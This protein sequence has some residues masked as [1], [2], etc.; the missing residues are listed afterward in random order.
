[1]VA[2]DVDKNIIAALQ[3]VVTSSGS[4]L[5]ISDITEI[6]I[7]SADA[8][9]TQIGSLVN[10]WVP[11]WDGVTEVDGVNLQFKLSGS[12]GWAAS[13]RKNSW[14]TVAGVSTPPDSIGV[15]LKYTYRFVTPLGNF[16]SAFSTGTLIIDDRTVMAINPT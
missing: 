4:Q 8:D 13:T 10:L 14:S 6:R 16:V 2:A 9:G 12:A 7:Y 15:S 5:S 3:R 11:G 1:M